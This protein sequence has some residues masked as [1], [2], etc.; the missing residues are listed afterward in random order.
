MA[1]NNAWI[2]RYEHGELDS[3][4]KQGFITVYK[5]SQL[6]RSNRCYPALQCHE[7]NEGILEDHEVGKRILED[8]ILS[9]NNVEQS[10]ADPLNVD[11]SNLLFTNL[12]QFSAANKA[13][14]QLDAL[15]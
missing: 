11:H 14:T 7:V 1:D 3:T 12:P 8:S 5:E 2:L 13:S 15:N 4:V 6:R 10:T 9:S